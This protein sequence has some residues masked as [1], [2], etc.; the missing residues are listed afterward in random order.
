VYGYLALCAA[1]TVIGLVVLFLE[2]R[3]LGSAFPF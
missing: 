1:L 3:V 2:R